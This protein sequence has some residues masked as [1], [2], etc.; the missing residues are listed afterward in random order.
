MMEIFSIRSMTAVPSWSDAAAGLGDAG[1]AR[2]ELGRPLGKQLVQLLDAHP[3]GLAKHPHRRP[4][5]LRRVLTAHERDD[6]PVPLRQ[7]AD[8]RLTRDLRAHLL[9]PLLGVEEETVVA[10]RDLGAGVDLRRHVRVLLT[11]GCACRRS[12]WPPGCRG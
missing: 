10:D 8:I 12:A 5:P 9:A 1:D 7:L 2:G 4:S 6:P 11:S 3:R